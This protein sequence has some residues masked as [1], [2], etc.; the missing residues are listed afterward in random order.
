MSKKLKELIEQKKEA[1]KQLMETSSFD[2]EFF[3]DTF[4]GKLRERNINNWFTEEVT[5]LAHEN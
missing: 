4:E 3:G 5:K 2:G 1:E